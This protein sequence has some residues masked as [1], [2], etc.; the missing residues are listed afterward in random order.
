MPRLR[1]FALRST[2]PFLVMA[3]ISWYQGF[4]SSMALSLLF[5]AVIWAWTHWTIDAFTRQGERMLEMKGERL[6]PMPP[7]W[8]MLILA[9]FFLVP[10]AIGIAVTLMLKN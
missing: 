9:G 1:R 2:I 5:A 6:P 10:M 8:D 7:R 4:W 3:A